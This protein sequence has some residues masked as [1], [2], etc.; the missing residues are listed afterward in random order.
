MRKPALFANLALL[1]VASL[2]LS[3]GAYE[4]T[5]Q[6]K[7][8][9]FNRC[10]LNRSMQMDVELIRKL[11]NSKKCERD[12]TWGVDSDGIWVDKGCKAVFEVRER[13]GNGYS[14][15]PRHGDASC[16]YP[17]GSNECEYWKDGYGKGMSDARANM[18]RAHER[19]KNAYDSRFE[20]AFA[21]GYRAGWDAYQRL[22]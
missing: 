17:K 16:P 22:R 4:L 14:E 15:K 8:K 18:S 1:A 20:S 12:R 9:V 3:A 5:C 13:A 11:D 21:E 6:S 19:H 7:E 10:N 2:P